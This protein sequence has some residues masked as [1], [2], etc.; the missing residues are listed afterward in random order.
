MDFTSLF[1]APETEGKEKHVPMIKRGSGHGGTHENVVIVAVGEE[2][3]HP[4]TTEHHIS[5][6]ELY[7]VKKEN[8]QVVFIGQ[9]DF[10]PGIAEPV[11][12]FKTVDLNQFKM[13]GALSYCNLHGV[14]K[15][16]LKL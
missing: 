7:G 9:A 13:L 6:I 11:A 14:W 2:T 4:N 1:K 10:A 16:T 5:R 3:A 12:T 8:D 15:N